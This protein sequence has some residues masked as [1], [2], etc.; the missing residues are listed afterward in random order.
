VGQLDITVA[1]GEFGPV[2]M[3]SGEADM[4]T[5][6]ELSGTLTAQLASGARY[7]TV[8]ISGLRFTDSSSM[9]ALAMAARALR[10][11]G[12]DLVLLRPQPT[13][14]RVLGLLSLDQV[15]TVRPGT[16]ADAEPT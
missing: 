14:A 10:E 8:D 3:L 4:T 5:A 11:Q 9:R 7:L 6:A 16:S 2:L 13:V 15:M 1:A 12:G